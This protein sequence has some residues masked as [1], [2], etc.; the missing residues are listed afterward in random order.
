MRGSDES[1]GSLFSYVDLEARVRGDH[2]LRTIREIANA[3]LSDLSK[4]FTALYADFG[5]PSI[6]PEKLLRA[7][8]L[9]AFYGIRS[10]R[11][12]MERLEFDLLFRW[13]V[14]LGVDDAVWDHSTFSK[15]R[16]RLLEGEIAAKFLSAVLAQ[17][18]VKR[19]LSSDHF[20][21]DGTLIEAWAS[22][23][24]FR[25]KDGGDDD[26]QGPGRNAERNFHKE[27]R[28]N[29]THQSTTDPDARL[30]KKGDGQPAKL[31]YMGHAL[32]ENRHGL[33]VGGGISQAT[34]TAER[35]TALE[36]ID[37]CR[38][39]GRRI[40]LGADKAYDVT[41]F[42]HDL[43]DRWVTP[44]IAIDGHLSKTGKRRK[45]AVDGRT[46]RHA[47]Y[48]ISQRCRKRIEEVFGW[49]KS[50]AGLA[51]VKLRGRARVDAA[52]T[53]ALAAYNLIRL[54]KLLA[55]PI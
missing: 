47:G 29:E 21:V 16:D 55:V 20:S 53:L 9:Q 42:V 49:I 40:T 19:L 18:K 43:R 4:A 1:S 38:R 30:Y 6:A 51:K 26:R 15:N 3:A 5:R 11:Q 17:P 45:T 25:S 22:I 44:H 33:A 28:S 48:D 52:F 13:F 41:L 2:P 34:G 36:L 31:C 14:G 35:E 27:K 7:M 12:L 23:K 37:E 46:T 50:S 39:R 10:E 32:M 24:S 54:P 8:L